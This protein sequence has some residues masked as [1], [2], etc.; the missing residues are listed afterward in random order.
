[1]P[2]DLDMLRHDPGL[3]LAA[4]KAFGAAVGLA[5]QPTMSRCENAPTTREL[6]AG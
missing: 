1:M 4:G 5:S 6:V 2:D 3:S